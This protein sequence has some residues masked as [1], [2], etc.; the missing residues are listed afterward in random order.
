[1]NSQH[2]KALRSLG[3]F[4]VARRKEQKMTRA[5]LIR[6][7]GLALSV[8]QGIEKGVSNPTF[9]TLKKLTTALDFELRIHPGASP[10][11]QIGYGAYRPLK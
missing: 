2:K 6:R 5:A 8:I 10:C 7:S 1:M 4:I 3:R 9:S 11:L